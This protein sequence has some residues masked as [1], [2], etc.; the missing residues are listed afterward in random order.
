MAWCENDT[1]MKTGLRKADVEF[2]DDTKKV[3]CHGCYALA[4]P[5]W[6]PPVEIVDMTDSTPARPKVGYVLQMSDQDGL[7]AKL[8]YGGLSLT[9]HAPSDDLHKIFKV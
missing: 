2:C 3:L 4:H 9:F 1:C 5:A 6:M 7:R 8:S